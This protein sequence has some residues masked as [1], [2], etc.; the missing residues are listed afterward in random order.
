M[1]F[2]IAALITSIC[3]LCG[4]FFIWAKWKLTYWQR[5][6]VP[7]LPTNLFF[8]NFADSIC[9][10]ISPGWLLGRLYSQAEPGSKFLGIYIFQ[11]P[12][13]LL[14]DPQLIKQMFIKDFNVFSGRYF[15]PKNSR[16]RIGTQNLFSIDNP[17]WQHLR[18]KLSPAFSSGKLKGLFG[19]MVE[20][21]ESLATHLENQ[22]KN[23]SGGRKCIEVKDA[24]TRYTTDIIS[25]LAF[26][27]HTNSFEKSASE[28]YTRSRQLFADDLISAIAIFCL[29]FF[30]RVFEHC[31]FTTFLGQQTTYFKNMFRSSMKAR[32]DT[33]SERGDIMDTLVK[34]RH[35]NDDGPFKFDEETLMAQSCLF[36]VAGLETS[37]TT[38]AFAL[39]ELAKSPDIQDRVRNEIIE[40]LEGGELTYEKVKQMNYLMQIISETLRIYPP[41]PILDRVSNR[42]YQIPG[43]DVIIERGTP[44]YVALPGIHM[45][46]DYFPNPEEFDPDRFKDERNLKSCTYMPFGEGPRICIGMRVGSLQTAVGLIRMLQNYRFSVNPS[47]EARV[48]RRGIFLKPEDGVHLYYE[49]ISNS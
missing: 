15:A 49:K 24:T 3:A 14:R 44:V 17:E 46:P 4:I 6:G 30:P 16:D 19:L 2:S 39:W 48:C 42:D 10:R 25:S 43:T 21:S 32:E 28:F 13:F 20:S 18:H 1:Q 47:H 29:G 37:A 35:E 41:A 26:G 38:M 5:R 8:G 9:G 7:T 36:F 27:V 22:F 23:H 33:K 40:K 31:L 34:L 11:Q 12:F 45:D